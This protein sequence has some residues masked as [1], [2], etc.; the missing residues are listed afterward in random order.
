MV[1]MPIILVHGRKRPEYNGM[2]DSLS[3]IYL[4]EQNDTK[5][6]YDK[7]MDIKDINCFQAVVVSTHSP[8]TKMTRGS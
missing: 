1:N 5:N 2:G 3:Y 4:K 7:L 8:N 6:K